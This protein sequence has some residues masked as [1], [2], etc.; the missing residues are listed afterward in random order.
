MTHYK[1]F[2]CKYYGK[3]RKILICMSGLQQMVG[4]YVDKEII[5]SII[6]LLS[7]HFIFNCQ[8]ETLGRLVTR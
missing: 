8:K 4:P 3:Q 6:Q 5:S 7:V 2:I 1:A